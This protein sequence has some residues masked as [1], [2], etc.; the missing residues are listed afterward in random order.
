MTSDRDSYQ[1]KA[2]HTL[3]ATF[4][5]PY[6]TEEGSRVHDVGKEAAQLTKIASTL[7]PSHIRKKKRNDIEFE[8]YIER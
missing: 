3:S 6:I 2:E 1:N 5:T 7:R 4:S 8:K